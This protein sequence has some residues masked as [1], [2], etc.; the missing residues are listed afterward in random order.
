MEDLKTKCADVTCQADDARCGAALPQLL[1]DRRQFH[2][3]KGA[4]QA[5]G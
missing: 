5:F 3:A 4:Q 1:V 2:S